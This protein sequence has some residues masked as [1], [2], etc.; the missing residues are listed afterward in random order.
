MFNV[1]FGTEK[2]GKIFVSRRTSWINARRGTYDFT[3]V[4]VKRD[5][6]KKCISRHFAPLVN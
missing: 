6:L 5:N 3:Q 1:P 4:F 2:T